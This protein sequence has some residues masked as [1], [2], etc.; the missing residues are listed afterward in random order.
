MLAEV[1][2]DWE[3][4]YQKRLEDLQKRESDAS[5]RLERKRQGADAFQLV[6]LRPYFAFEFDRQ[7]FEENSY[8]H[9][10]RMLAEMNLLRQRDVENKRQAELAQSTLHKQV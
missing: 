8:Q 6:L 2:S 7:E 10:Q 9:R 4:A 5:D 1:K 3:K